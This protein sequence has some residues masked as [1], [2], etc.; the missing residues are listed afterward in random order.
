MPI[1]WIDYGIIND[2]DSTKG[3]IILCF[4]A[5]A[6]GSARAAGYA[7]AAL[8]TATTFCLAGTAICLVGVACKATA[9]LRYH[10]T[11]TVLGLAGLFIMLELLLLGLGVFAMLELLLSSTE[12]S[13]LEEVI[14]AMLLELELK[15]ELES[16]SAFTGSEQATIK[17]LAKKPN[18]YK[19]LINT[20][21]VIKDYNR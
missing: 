13:L 21:L 12:S 19:Y 2:I 8:G 17:K 1:S 6:F 10:Y 18:K 9:A 4:E 5:A 11:A 20:P 3:D 14:S 15:L 7:T 16:G